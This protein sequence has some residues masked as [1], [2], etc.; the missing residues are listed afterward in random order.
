MI[1]PN[2]LHSLLTSRGNLINDYKTQFLPYQDLETE[3]YLL[4]GQQL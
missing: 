3:V 1:A 4:G 2:W